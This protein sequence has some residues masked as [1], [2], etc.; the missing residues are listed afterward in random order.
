MLPSGM[1][2]SFDDSQLKPADTLFIAFTGVSHGLGGI[3]FEFHRSL[4]GALC[5]TLFV[6]D[7]DQSWYQ[8][9]ED[10][11]AQLRAL[12]QR[13]LTQTGAAKTVTLGNSMGGF[14]ALLFGALCGADEIVA[15]AAQTAIGPDATATLSDERWREYQARIAAFPFPD[16]ALLPSPNAKVTLVCGADDLLDRAH[17]AHLADAWPITI[18][19]VDGAG[20][21]VAA[22][23]RD[24][25]QLAPLLEVA[26]A[27]RTPEPV[28][29]G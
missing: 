10:A 6:R 28:Q 18:Q 9:D 19:L 27:L 16:L 24:R 4:R 1:A 3:P 22:V 2:L 21:D 20:H 12:V 15:F 23:L 25:D 26:G 7:P 11:V 17:A 29:G 13:A 14:G 5:A 8:Y